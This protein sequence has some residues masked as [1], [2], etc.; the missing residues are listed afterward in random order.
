MRERGVREMG[1]AIIDDELDAA[2]VKKL[3]R[4]L[5]ILLSNREI[6]SL[7]LLPRTT[8]SRLTSRLAAAGYLLRSPETARY[9]LG[10]RIKDLGTFEMSEADLMFVARPLLE[11]IVESAPV[12]VTLYKRS[13]SHLRCLDVL[14][15]A[16]EFSERL[17]STVSLG[18]PGAGHAILAMLPQSE[19]TDLLRELERL[20]R[21]EDV[22][23][24][25]REIKD[26]VM[27]VARKGFYVKV[28]RGGSGRFS[29][30]SVVL[31]IPDGDQWFAFELQGHAGGISLDR[32]DYDLGPALVHVKRKIEA[33]L[34]M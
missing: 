23:S 30:V 18:V 13:N 28:G 5:K 22:D 10:Y 2:E 15:A 11:E 25:R 6:S 1:N 9:Q 31:R 17:D 26:A 4:G 20:G 29:S 24:V 33:A 3:A 16:S 12:S 21:G 27:Q 7:T 14:G 32:L 19:Q 8:V 34:G